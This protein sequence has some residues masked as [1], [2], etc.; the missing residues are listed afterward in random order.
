MFKC[1][2]H[3]TF[4]WVKIYFIEY[5]YRYII[6]INIIIPKTTVVNGGYNVN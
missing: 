3:L 6:V 2:Y 1:S 4:R 5:Y